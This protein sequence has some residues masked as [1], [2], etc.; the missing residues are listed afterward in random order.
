[1]V[2]APGAAVAAPVAAEEVRSGLLAV[3]DGVCRII[4]FLLDG[5]LV[6]LEED[7]GRFIVTI[8]MV[9][10]IAQHMSG[11]YRRRSLF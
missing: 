6:H 9:R 10:A 4:R 3:A 5:D 1:M 11:M 2:E 7:F 8:I